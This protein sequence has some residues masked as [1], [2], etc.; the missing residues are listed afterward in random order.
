MKVPKCFR[1]VRLIDERR[2]RLSRR[3]RRVNGKTW[4][5]GFG[6]RGKRLKRAWWC[7]GTVERLGHL[8]TFGR[9]C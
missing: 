7:E 5:K 3:E 9:P 1:E 4:L 8:G 2:M 6:R